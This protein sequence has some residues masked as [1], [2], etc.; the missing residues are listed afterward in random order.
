VSTSF[1]F[2]AWPPPCAYILVTFGC[3]HIELCPGR[4]AFNE[5]DAM[6]KG[7]SLQQLT[8]SECGEIRQ[9]ALRARRDEGMSDLIR[10]VQSLYEPSNCRSSC[11][12][13]IES[14]S[15]MSFAL[16]CCFLRGTIP[17]AVLFPLSY[18]LVATSVVAAA[19][20]EAAAVLT[21]CRCCCNS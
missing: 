4:T 15:A 14:L 10:I 8:T 7:S 21:L 11:G 17:S 13:A 5:Q 9:S 20:P 1:R 3:A 19:I 6:A 12:H 16:S 18:C 2:V